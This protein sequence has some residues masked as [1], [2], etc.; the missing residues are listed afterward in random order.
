MFKTN[1]FKASVVIGGFSFLADIVA[2][3]RDRILA[4]QFGA[5][6]TLDIYYSAFKIPDL[7]FNLL[8]LGA[9]SSA[10]IPIFIRE[11][12]EDEKK[13]W[14]L[15]QNFVTMAFVSVLSGVLVMMVFARPLV[16][17]IAPGFSGPDKDV[18][19]QL[20]RLM[21]ISPLVFSLSTILGSMLQALERFWAYAIAPVFYNAGIIVGA[22]YFVPWFRI[23]GY[24]EVLGLGAGVVFGA[25]LH[26]LIQLIASM[27]AGFRFKW[28]FNVADTQFRNIVRLMIPRTVGLGAYSFD[29][30]VINSIASTLGAGSIAVLNFANNL[31]FVPIAV[32]GVSM[33]TAI[34]PKLSRHAS[35]DEKDDLKKNLYLAIKSTALIVVPVAILMAIFS[36]RIISVLFG[37]GLF[38]G[39]G[40]EATASV[41]AIFMVG[42]TAQSLIPI[43]SRGFYALQ[44]TKIPVL[45]SVFSVVINISLAFYFSKGLSW[46][47]QGLAWAISVSGIIQFGLL[48][49]AF[50]R[51]IKNV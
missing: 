40:I 43:I 45:I 3:F 44:N 23:R 38:G 31:Q 41:L 48:W 35:S 46:D 22:I 33:A 42:V 10:F 6:R 30:V 5:S 27:R 28:I 7:V 32:V 26:L 16:E 34:F 4:S 9:V 25:L 15:S 19:V 37:A 51:F 49:L 2:L 8:I 12:K 29:S 13:A 17:L 14:R 39:V 1:L 24:H 11:F 47:I 36:R 21:L 20:M 50:T 18:L